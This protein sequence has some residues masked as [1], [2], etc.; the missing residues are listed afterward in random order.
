MLTHVRC[1][2]LKVAVPVLAILTVIFIGGSTPSTAFA[3]RSYIS[4]GN[5]SFLSILKIITFAFNAKS[6]A[7]AILV[8]SF[9]FFFFHFFWRDCQKL[10]SE[11]FNLSYEENVWPRSD[12]F[13]EHT[14]TYFRKNCSSSCY[15]RRVWHM[16]RLL[17][18]TSIYSIQKSTRNFQKRPPET[19]NQIIQT[20]S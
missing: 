13:L 16:I 7:I 15:S 1:S 12:S 11:C 20:A 9:F 2:D 10:F 8:F 5:Y 4:V 6:F 17:M 14:K 19:R 3:V 18:L